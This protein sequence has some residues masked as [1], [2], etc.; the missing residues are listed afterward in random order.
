M[1]ALGASLGKA[2]RFV[3]VVVIARNEELTISS[4]VQAAIGSLETALAKGKVEG[5]EVIL[6]DSASTDATVQIA[7]KYPITI[8][9]LR[10]EWP[11]SAAAGRQIGLEHSR[12]DLIFFIDGDTVVESD[13][14]SGALDYIN[15]P[16]VAAVSGTV[17]ET[18]T[19]DSMLAHEI[20]AYLVRSRPSGEFGEIE[21]APIGLFRREVL[22][23]VSGFHPFLRGAEDLD[24][25]FRIA[26]GGRRIIQT[27][28][29]MAH[30]RWSSDGRDVRFI[31]YFRSVAWWSFGSGQACRYRFGNREIRSKYLDRYINARFAVDYFRA[32]VLAVL[33]LLQ[34]VIWLTVPFGLLVLLL[35]DLGVFGVVEHRRRATNKTWKQIVFT[36]HRMGYAVIRHAGFALGLLNRIPDPSDYPRQT[37]AVQVGK[38]WTANALSRR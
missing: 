23:A 17:F 38:T 2:N 27:R 19:G 12:G 5:G 33:V 16:Q 29:A 35:L 22:D 34:P 14:L 37:I 32:L 31:D 21:V 26:L 24:L 3:S 1:T 20:Q 7:R 28:A 15:E 4:C 18:E 36:F 25:G 13:W 8:L 10:K 9:R 30:H 6:V 11:M